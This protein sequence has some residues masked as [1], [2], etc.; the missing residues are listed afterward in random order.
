MTPSDIIRVAILE[1]HQ[2]IIDGY[3][4]RL[5]QATDIE[6]VAI[7]T[8]TVELDRVLNKQKPDVLLLDIF[9]QTSPENPNFYPILQDIPRWLKKFPKLSILVI[10]M[11]QTRSLVR[12][13]MD[14]GASGYILKDDTSTIQELVSVIRSVAKGGVHL[15][16]RVHKYLLTES[17]DDALITTRQQQVLS[18]CAAYPDA[19]TNELADKLGVAPS[20]LRNLLSTAYLR[21]DVHNR[22]AAITK[23]RQLGLITPQDPSLHI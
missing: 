17:P 16:K 8:F 4:Y 22:T 12:A 14:A 7:A 10:S 15:S 9:V 5:G 23:A 19:S 3:L 11:H 2:S 18:L 20:T 1:D 21:L 6:V 13:V